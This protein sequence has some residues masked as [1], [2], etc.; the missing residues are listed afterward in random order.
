MTDAE[1]DAYD[2]EHQRL[3][4]H[5]VAQKKVAAPKIGWIPIG[6]GQVAECEGE[7]P[8]PL[9]LLRRDP[10]TL[11]YRE[12]VA[13]PYHDRVMATSALAARDR[14]DEEAG[15][16]RRLP[17]EE[18]FRLLQEV[19]EEEDRTGVRI[20]GTILIGKGYC[21]HRDLMFPPDDEA[22]P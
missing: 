20:N 18:L 14:R 21:I 4:Q 12:W 19:S 22:D 6:K 5:V 8:V 16:R 17:E 2:T 1:R 15:R 7:Q 10:A 9:R 11:S 3:V 13:L